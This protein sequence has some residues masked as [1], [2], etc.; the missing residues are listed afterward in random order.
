MHPEVTGKGKVFPCSPAMNAAFNCAC[1]H[2]TCD[3]TYGLISMQIMLC[4]GNDDDE[5]PFYIV[6]LNCGPL[7][8]RMELMLSGRFSGY[9][10]VVFELPVFH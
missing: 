4:P 9:K 2:A 1:D 5:P 10:L 6:S 3:L 8:Q 7:L